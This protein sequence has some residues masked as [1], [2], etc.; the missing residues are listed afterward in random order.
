MLFSQEVRD[1]A[2]TNTKLGKLP[3]VEVKN[4]K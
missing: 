2:L 4:L 1:Q 3:T